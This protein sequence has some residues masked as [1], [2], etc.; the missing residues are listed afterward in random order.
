[1]PDS[2]S[3]EF[4]NPVFSG[5]LFLDNP[6]GAAGSRLEV[7]LEAYGAG[8]ETRLV[9]LGNSWSFLRDS[10][11]GGSTL[12]GDVSL[13][14]TSKALAVFCSFLPLRLTRCTGAFSGDSFLLFRGRSW[15]S[16]EVKI[17]VAGSLDAEGFLA[18]IKFAIGVLLMP[19]I[20]LN[21]VSRCRG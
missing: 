21:D 11:A 16:F 8:L 2:E 19:R 20:E 9:D 10:F 5:D 4:A 13:L 15:A 1:M 7:G 6:V 3:C 14:G 17:W 12:L 18:G